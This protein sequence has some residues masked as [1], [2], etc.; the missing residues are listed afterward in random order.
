MAFSAAEKDELRTIITGAVSDAH[1][2]MKEE[3]I[4]ALRANCAVME[5]FA[6]E[7]KVMNETIVKA[8]RSLDVGTTKIA[9]IEADIVKLENLHRHDNEE[10][11]K[12]VTNLGSIVEH[13]HAPIIE[14]V[15]VLKNILR[16]LLIVV[17]AAGLIGFVTWT[18]RMFADHRAQTEITQHGG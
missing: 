6:K 8:L 16:G 5:D 9:R 4:A 1:V 11:E 14:D 3:E 15:T 7:V 18:M 10:L 12:R 13:S 17:L 2:C